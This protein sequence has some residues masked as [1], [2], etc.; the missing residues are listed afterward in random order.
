MTADDVRKEALNLITDISP[1][2]IKEGNTDEITRVLFYISGVVDMAQAICE[3][4][5]ENKH[6]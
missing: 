6:G 5:E 4:M 1:W 3:K 2:E